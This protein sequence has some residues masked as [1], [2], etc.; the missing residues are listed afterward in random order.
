MK[1]KSTGCNF[2]N[3]AYQV[4]FGRVNIYPPPLLPPPPNS[5]PHLP[6]LVSGPAQP[7][8]IKMVYYLKARTVP[9]LP[10]LSQVILELHTLAVQMP[11]YCFSYCW[12]SC[13]SFVE[14]LLSS[15]RISRL[16]R[17]P[18]RL[19]SHTICYPRLIYNPAASTSLS[20][21]P[22]GRIADHLVISR[23]ALDS[24]SLRY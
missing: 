19:F 7:R 22:H 8:N 16:L 14:Y 18:I 20:H 13:C 21:S 3:L 1:M 11:F 4:D 9:T 15:I 24:A 2:R 6:F 10:Y 5:I 12:C 23:A 17:L